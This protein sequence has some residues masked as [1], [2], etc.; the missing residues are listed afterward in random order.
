MIMEKKDYSEDSVSYNEGGGGNQL[1]YF[2]AALKYNNE[3]YKDEDNIE[4]KIINVRR[5]KL[6]KGEDWEIL[7]NKK[8]VL[9]LKGIRFNNKEKEFFRTVEGI[10]FIMNGWKNG[11]DSVLKFKTEVKKIKGKKL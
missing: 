7:E 6:R 2:N 10:N 3:F 1:K 8:V 9:I 5:A 11:W 4:L